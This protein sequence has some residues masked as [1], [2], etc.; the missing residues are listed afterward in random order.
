[1]SGDCGIAVLDGLSLPLSPLQVIKAKLMDVS[2]EVDNDVGVEDAGSHCD[3]KYQGI[4]CQDP[5]PGY[6]RD[7][8][9]SLLAAFGID[10]ANPD[11]VSG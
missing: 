4:S 9:A 5:A 3:P 11:L 1:M 6:Y 10:R 2:L 8:D 7:R